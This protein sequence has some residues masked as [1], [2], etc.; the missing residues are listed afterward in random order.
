MISI[1]S[2]LK[3]LKSSNPN[4]YP[5]R[6][7]TYRILRVW[8]EGVRYGQAQHHTNGW[9]CRSWL[10]GCLVNLKQCGQTF[11]AVKHLNS[12]H[13]LS[14]C[15]WYN[16][17]PCWHCARGT[18]PRILNSLSKFGQSFYIKKYFPELISS[19]LWLWRHFIL[20]YF[21]VLLEWKNMLICL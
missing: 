2:F 17:Q 10:T 11:L 6:W 5:R 16:K 9:E 1:S 8:E 3:N 13:L 12:L 4:I 15:S 7:Y 20:F 19:V 14:D 18:N 21:L